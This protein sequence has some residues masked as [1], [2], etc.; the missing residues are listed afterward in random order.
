MLERLTEHCIARPL[1]AWVIM[2]A[3]SLVGGLALAG[4]GISQYP[5][6]DRLEISVQA[7]LPGAPPDA[8][9]RDVCEPIEEALAQ[10]EGIVGLD[11]AVRAG[12]ATVTV[13]LQPGRD[14]DDALQ[15]AQNRLARISDK[16]PR[17]L[18]P[19]RLSKTNP[20]DRPLVI[21]ALSGP[22]SRQQLSDAAR[23]LVSDAMQ[24]VPGVGAID[25][26][27]PQTR[28]VQ[29]W[30]D[31]T[32]LE[33]FD[34]T[35]GDVIAGIERNNRDVSGG[36]VESA[37]GDLGVRITGQPPAVA[38][39]A[40][41]V[42]VSPTGADGTAAPIRLGEV[43]VIEDGFLETR[44]INRVDGQ[45]RQGIG[46]SK[47]RG[48][49]AVSVAAGIRATVARLAPTLP[50][51]M[52]LEVSYDN[53]DFIVSSI[54][55]MWH[56]LAVAV[57]LTAVVCW[58]FLGALWAAGSVLLAIP[59]ALLGTVAALWGWGA[60]LNT[61][62]LLGLALAI[63]L[64]VDDAIMVQES[65]DRMRGQG[66]DPR[67]SA[68]RGT[69]RVRFAALAASIAVLAV[70]APVMFMRGEVGASFLQFGLALCVAVGLSYVEAVTLAPARAAQFMGGGSAV[71]EPRSWN[72]LEGFYGRVLEVVLRRPLLVLGA[73]VLVTAGGAAALLNLPRE[74]T[75]EQD[76][77]RLEA[78]WTAPAT[79]DQATVEAI[80]TEMETAL[81]AIPGVA[82][83]QVNANGTSGRV[84]IAL[85]P[86][87]Q[88]GAQG[89]ILATVRAALAGI[90]G[91]TARAR[92]AV[93]DLVQVPDA[94][95]ADISIRGPE[96]QRCADLA[97]AI[98]RRWR[99]EPRLIEA[100]TT[101]RIAAAE[102][103]VEPDRAAMADLGVSVEELAATVGGLVGGTGAGTFTLDGRRQDVRVR[104]RADQRAT[105][106]DLGR[107]RLR[108]RS[109][110]TVPLASVAQ[111]VVRPAPASLTRLD[112]EP[113]VKISANA[114]PGVSQEQAQ[115]IAL[116]LVGELPA[117]YRAVPGDSAQAFRASLRDLGFALI[118][119]IVA[120]YL[121]LVV[122]FNSLVHPL[123][124]LTV[125]PLAAAGAGL[126]LLAG[127]QT[128]NLYSG[129][130]MLLLMGLAK[131]NS[132]LLVDR[133]NHAR[134]AGEAA[135]AR[136]AMR[137]AG[138]DRLRAIL[139]TS[140]A[141][142]AAALPIVLGLGDGAEVRRPMAL[143]ILGGIA[144]ST[145]LS[146]VAVPAFYVLVDR[147]RR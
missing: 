123:T 11:S 121:V 60:T 38:D 3:M 107:L 1:T 52:R 88:R 127:G 115:A 92:P 68:R 61:F 27:G 91:L 15:D 97:D 45:A 19:V 106:D 110:G 70:F 131:K 124:V 73:V 90:P 50:Q 111:L 136:L 12:R 29:V 13:R 120:A 82:S 36:T 31:R 140:T 5:D 101:W 72:V 22:F 77:G 133:A 42:I 146:L 14:V 83:V 23:Y 48:A 112:R 44:R 37:G 57:L 125:L 87:A 76:A 75:P 142:C 49:N 109:G 59:M 79:A 85:L 86:R 141:T 105:P 56:E 126:A 21:L 32:R 130:G 69:A 35:V 55:A 96:H 53:S 129:I 2:V 93:Q 62:T 8:M 43:G 10:S 143:A 20:E 24:T 78:P 71:H 89:P 17:D 41:M 25:L 99:D 65:I 113:A 66:L 80:V 137:L 39:L 145:L 116:G 132:I 46:I 117:G 30:L 81:M 28:A 6:V 108:T 84:L 104:L 118:A 16:L 54:S 40:G 102:I 135:D 4:I 7:E 128:L 98:V 58:V 147:F 95:A 26:F 33:A 94:A 100:T 9:E 34:L 144:I 63:G 119:G 103:R 51:G 18:L 74:L 64:V 138:P 122:Q 67:E 139:M 114:A 134:E 47:Q